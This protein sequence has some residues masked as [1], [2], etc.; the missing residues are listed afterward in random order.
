MLFKKACA[1][2][3]FC[4]RSGFS[5]CAHQ[6]GCWNQPNH[7]PDDFDPEVEERAL[8]NA[9]MTYLAVRHTELGDPL[10]EELN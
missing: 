4:A 10:P 1:P 9:A 7:L 5:V 6:G 3:G 8:L 2:C